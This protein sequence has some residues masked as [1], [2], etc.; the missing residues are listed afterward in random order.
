MPRKA[1]KKAPARFAVGSRV[2]VKAG[3]RDPDYPDMPLGGWSGKVQKIGSD[4]AGPTYLVEWD[5]HTR[6][7]MHPVYRS[8]CKHEHLDPERMWLGEDDLEPEQGQPAAIELPT[9]LPSGP[10]DPSDQEGPGS[11]PGPRT[12]QEWLACD[13]PG[14]MLACLRGKAS[15][16]KFRLFAVACC[17]RV[18]DLLGHE[19]HRHRV[20]TA[21]QYVDGQVTEHAVEDVASGGHDGSGGPTEAAFWCCAEDFFF[22][23]RLVASQARRSDRRLSLEQRCKT[24]LVR[25]LFG[26]PF[27]PVTLTPAWR[28]PTVIAVARAAYEE[29][30][31][32]GGELDAGQ[33][34]VLADA[35]EDAGCTNPDIP[36]HLRGPGPHVRGC[37]AVDL[38]LGLA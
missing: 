5:R 10:I 11:A 9:D 15:E 23:A 1:R 30:H 27:D 31:L 12:G 18:W 14:P 6:R 37:W 29:R 38:C 24:A 17:R 36:G 26:N 13:D 4:A 19:R 25:D 8:R 33:L 34:A 28:T 7:H 32:P 35:L 2:R 22:A 3:I 21:E 20:E 16:R